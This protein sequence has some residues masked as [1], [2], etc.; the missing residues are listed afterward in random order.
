MIDRKMVDKDF[1]RLDSLIKELLKD[2]STISGVIIT[3]EYFVKDVQGYIYSHKAKVIRNEQA[4]Y[5]LPS[6]FEIVGERCS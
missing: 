5:L 1:E 4:K 6:D 2:N 3:T